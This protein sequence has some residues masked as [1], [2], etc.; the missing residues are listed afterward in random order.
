MQLF[1]WPSPVN[2]CVLEAL[3]FTAEDT[4]GLTMYELRESSHLDVPVL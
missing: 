2:R 1:L 4:P 3:Y